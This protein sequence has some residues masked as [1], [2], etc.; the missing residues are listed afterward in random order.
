[1]TRN[2]TKY[3]SLFFDLDD[4]LWDTGHNNKECLE[5]IYDAYHFGRH[6]PSFEAF[7]NTY[8]PHN[9]LLWEQYRN[10][11]I[12]RQ[13][14]LLERLLHVL[15]PMGIDDRGYALNLNK[16]FLQRTTTKTRTIAGAKELLEYLYAGGYRLFIISNGFREIQSLK[17]QNCGLA[18]YFERIIL[19]EDA[20]IRKP[21]KGIFDFA[22]INTNSCRSE[23]LMIGDSWDADIAGARQAKI[24][25]LWFNPDNLPP[26]RFE[27]TYN[28][29]YLSEI[30]EI[31]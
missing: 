11:E 29:S 3:K 6:Y 9:L 20:S 25:Q 30:K 22:L 10:H 2:R 8:M 12:D 21:H 15:R 17:L 14:L 18:S 5:E 27:P 28:V 31:L 26:S 23:S 7:F 16:D 1:M 13:T 4:T 19:S 24:D